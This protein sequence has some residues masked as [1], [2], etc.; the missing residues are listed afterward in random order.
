MAPH[1]H[2]RAVKYVFGHTNVGCHHKSIFF[3]NYIFISASKKYWLCHSHISIT[4]MSWCSRK[5]YLPQYDVG[6]TKYHLEHSK[7]ILGSKNHIYEK[8]NMYLHLQIPISNHVLHIHSKISPN[9]YH[10]NKYI[11]KYAFSNQ[12]Q[13]YYCFNL[14]NKSANHN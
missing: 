12:Y 14:E 8:P 13:C 3:P 9:T 6:M 1:S 2:N 4:M 5:R 7:L 11:S 10:T